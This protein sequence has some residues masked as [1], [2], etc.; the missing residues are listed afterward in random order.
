[1]K[2]VTATIQTGTATIAHVAPNIKVQANH[3]SPGGEGFN[4]SGI[5]AKANE[6]IVGI[7]KEIKT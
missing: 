3:A 1:L 4:S 7:I 2:T 6:T 5:K